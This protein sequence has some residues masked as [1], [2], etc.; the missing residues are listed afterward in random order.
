M[1][2]KLLFIIMLLLINAVLV[3]CEK[4]KV[5]IQGKEAMGEV[6]EQSLEVGKTEDAEVI[7]QEPANNMED[8]ATS[9]EAAAGSDVTYGPILMPEPS[10]GYYIAG[11][12]NDKEGQAIK[13]NMISSEANNITDDDEWFINHDLSL[14]PYSLTGSLQDITGNL[15]DEIDQEVNG[16]AVTSVFQDDSY[17]YYTYG[18]NYSEGYILNIYDVN[19]HKKA[20]SLDFSNYR[21]APEYID[22]DYDYIQQKINWA[23]IQDNILY[24]THSHNTYAKS[25]DNMNAYITA[26]DLTDMGILW[27]T[28]ALVCNSHNF[29]MIGD[30]IICGYGFTDEADF[31]YQINKKSG[32]V[33]E[34][35]PL[36]SAPSYIIEKDN[37]LYVCTY[38]TDYEFDIMR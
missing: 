21:Y 16:M 17:L 19:T 11:S 1:K 8:A 33:L 23:E 9:D 25:S 10:F 13:L 24:V 18:S 20:Y 31:L 26:I 38:N 35:T 2:K 30:V 29:Q 36:K 12:I 4:D 28:D 32:K 3:S 22:T 7:T 27:R 37:V 34:K 5:N 15:P 6:T 14:S